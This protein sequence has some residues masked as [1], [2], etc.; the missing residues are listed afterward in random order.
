MGPK[1]AIDVLFRRS[2]Q[3]KGRRTDEDDVTFIRGIFKRPIEMQVCHK[4]VSSASLTHSPCP[5]M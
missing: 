4:A 5:K 1:V 2:K 3:T